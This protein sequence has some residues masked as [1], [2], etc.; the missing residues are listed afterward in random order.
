MLVE[1]DHRIIDGLVFPFDIGTSFSIFAKDKS[2]IVPFF[3][4]KFLVAADIVDM[5]GN[6]VTA[7]F[8]NSETIP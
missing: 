5:K 7:S 2:Y 3:E 4:R 1:R 8:H 6:V